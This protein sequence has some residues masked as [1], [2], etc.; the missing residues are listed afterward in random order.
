[1]ELIGDNFPDIHFYLRTKNK[2]KGD[3][4]T[5]GEGSWELIGD[6]FPKDTQKKKKNKI[7][8]IGRGIGGLLVCIF[9]NERQKVK[10]QK[11]SDTSPTSPSR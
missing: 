1:M 5:V 6:L 11:T 7:G 4:G 10:K 3:L 8:I 9:V 2:K